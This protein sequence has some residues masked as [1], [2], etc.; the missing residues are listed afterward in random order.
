MR[1]G[2]GSRLLKNVLNLPKNL[3]IHNIHGG[4]FWTELPILSSGLQFLF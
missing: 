2:K 1:V 3:Y 4:T